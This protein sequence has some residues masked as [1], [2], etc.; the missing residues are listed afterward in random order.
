M[1]ENRKYTVHLDITE[2]ERGTKMSTKDTE[3]TGLWVRGNTMKEGQ[4][5]S[6]EKFL[7]DW[8]AAEFIEKIESAG[9]GVKVDIVME[10]EGRF[11]NI[12]GVYSK[13]KASTPPASGPPA[14]GPPVETPVQKE[15]FT[16]DVNQEIKQQP[17]VFAQPAVNNK[18]TA[19]KLAVELSGLMLQ[20]GIIKTTKATPSVI[21]EGVLNLAT[22][23]EGYIEGEDT[24]PKS[25]A[26]PLKP[27]EGDGDPGVDDSD[28][29]F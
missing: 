14:S 8:N 4:P 2:L 28:I 6:W 25:D 1:T 16:P 7:M 13:G 10:K 12:K 15:M 22:R 24:M 29:P 11:W 26:S 21:Y 18:Y 20:T 19:L 5:E 17:A 9:I 27:V 3:M 23:F